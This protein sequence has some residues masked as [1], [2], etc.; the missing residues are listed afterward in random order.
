[1]LQIL[2]P[3]IDSDLCLSN[4]V[5]TNHKY[6]ILERLPDIAYHKRD[7]NNCEV[8]LFVCIRF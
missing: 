5:K 7:S 3:D 1:M 6:V 2:N 8:R 4:I